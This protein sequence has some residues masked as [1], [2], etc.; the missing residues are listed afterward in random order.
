VPGATAYVAHHQPGMDADADRQRDA[1]LLLHTCIQD[2]YGRD[3]TQPGTYSARRVVF[4]GVRIAKVDQESIA[5]ILC[6]RAFE[7]LDH[8]GTG[9]LIG[10]DD[11]AQVFRVELRGEGG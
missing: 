1:P 5:Q 9:L 7:A 2:A 11:L 6:D 8:L 3:H 10:A 4:V